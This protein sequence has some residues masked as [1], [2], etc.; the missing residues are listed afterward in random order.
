MVDISTPFFPTAACTDGSVQNGTHTH[1]HT[2]TLAL[3]HLNLSQ[4][5]LI[6]LYGSARALADFL[7]R[8]GVWL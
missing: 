8:S 4:M 2:H 1:A 6:D 3:P 7:S 5:T